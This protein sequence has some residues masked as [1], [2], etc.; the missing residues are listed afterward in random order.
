VVAWRAPYAKRGCS[1]A[2]ASAQGGAGK[3]RKPWGIFYT[4]SRL[5][6]DRAQYCFGSAAR[7]AI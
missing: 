4:W 1:L 6:Y 7:C 2:D 5:V 3:L